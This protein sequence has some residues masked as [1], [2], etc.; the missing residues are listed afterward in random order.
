M[1]ISCLA[2]VIAPAWE[3]AARRVGSNFGTLFKVE[4]M[5][6]PFGVY[7]PLA[8]L[9]FVLTSLGLSP[10]VAP[11]TPAFVVVVEDRLRDRLRHQARQRRKQF[12]RRRQL[13]HERDMVVRLDPGLIAVDDSEERSAFLKWALSRL[14]RRPQLYRSALAFVART[15]KEGDWNDDG[16]VAGT[17][18]YQAVR[19]RVD[20]LGQIVTD[21]MLE[22]AGFG[23]VR[24]ARKY[25]A[26]R[27]TEFAARHN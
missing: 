25:F 9:F 16:L 1:V 23:S 22:G 19:A 21:R 2:P 15:Y 5:S 11:T 4:G 6:G 18:G 17:S 24:R 26:D 3:S 14:A 10:W 13:P 27:W 7:V 20:L 12:E 8:E